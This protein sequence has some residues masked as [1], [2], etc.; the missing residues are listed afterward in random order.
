MK[1]IK[2]ILL[3]KLI[4]IITMS[5]LLLSSCSKDNDPEISNP[6]E[7][8]FYLPVV[9]H[10]IHNG[11]QIGEGSNLSIER[12]ERQIEILNEDYRKKEGTRGYN[13]HPD[14]GDAKIE[15]VLAKRDPE[16]NPFNGINRIDS[17]K[18][19]VPPLGYNQ[20]HYAQYAYWD[21]KD[22]I[23]IWTTPLPE[24]FECQALGL[25]TLPETGL[26]GREHSSFPQ[27]GDAEGILINWMHFGESDI[28]CYARFGRT[29]THEM[30]HY[31]GVLHTWG[32]GDC[33]NNDYCNDTPAVDK[34]VYNKVFM[35]CEGEPAMIN[36][37][38]T[39]AHDKTMNMFTNDQIARMH[40]VLKHHKGRKA[41]LSSHALKP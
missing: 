30:G 21:P 19:T 39:W 38:M 33:E 8:I 26:P 12:I 27:P 11:K 6:K 15:F 17:T 23:N 13:N 40:Y 32:F 29:L 10:I 25:A 35:A 36:N 5:L 22:Y 18:V 41:L 16:G 20:N 37:Y 34:P 4:M 9:V 28:A 3:R 24:S 1:I 14:G 31:L 2:H 7:G